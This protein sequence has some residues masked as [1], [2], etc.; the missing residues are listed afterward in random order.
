M[1]TYLHKNIYPN[2]LIS[3][4]PISQKVRGERFTNWWIDKQNVEYYLAI[5]RNEVLKKKKWNT[6]ICHSME[7]LWKY[8]AKSKK[9]V[10][11]GHIKKGGGHILY[12]SVY[13]KYPE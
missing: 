1:K 2:I 4:I 6:Y 3:I 9:S 5:K 11:K 13:M 12:H 7:E 10:K 8:Y